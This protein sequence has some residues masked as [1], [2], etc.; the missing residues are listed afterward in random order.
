MHIIKQYHGRYLMKPN[1]MNFLLN[2]SD[3][4]CFLREPFPFSTVLLANI[5][6][7]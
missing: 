1:R 6:Y 2:I 7:I 5:N 3:F 4:V